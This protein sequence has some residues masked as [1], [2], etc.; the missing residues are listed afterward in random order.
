[1]STS[2]FDDRLMEAG[3]EIRKI[4]MRLNLPDA[5]ATGAQEVYRDVSQLVQ[6]ARLAL[7]QV[8][9]VDRHLLGQ[10]CLAW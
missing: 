8:A 2:S 6:V 1:M 5:T 3:R 4:C 9:L 10:S 7:H